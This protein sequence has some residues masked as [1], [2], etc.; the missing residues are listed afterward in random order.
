MAIIPQTLPHIK[1]ISELTNSP[2]FLEFGAK[3]QLFG[4]E[5]PT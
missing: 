2:F 3:G 5:F 1:Q 4:A